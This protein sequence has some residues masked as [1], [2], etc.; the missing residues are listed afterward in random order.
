MKKELEQL[1][2]QKSIFD[3]CSAQEGKGI[4]KKGEYNSVYQFEDPSDEIKRW[5]IYNPHK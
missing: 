4:A 5:K 3:D 2:E 1:L